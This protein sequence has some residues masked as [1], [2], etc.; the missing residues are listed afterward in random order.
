MM[1][2]LA[3][4]LL[5]LS[6]S[7]LLGAGCASGTKHA[8]ES[9]SPQEALVRID[10]SVDISYGLGRNQYR[11]LLQAKA[12]KMSGEYSLDKQ[13]V[14][15]CRLD[16]TKYAEFVKRAKAFTEAPKRVPAQTQSAP[17]HSPFTVTVRVGE[18]QQV[19]SGCRALDEGALSHLVK[20]GEFLLY[21]KK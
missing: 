1:R 14:K 5:T 17:C 12:E 18:A 9:L 15:A 20:E 6:L 7:L 16:P 19:A 21:S 11:L 8:E 13:I 4:I 2:H 10:S 3:K